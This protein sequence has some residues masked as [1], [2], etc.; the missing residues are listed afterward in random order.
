MLFSPDERI[1]VVVFTNRV[2]NVRPV[3]ELLLT[4]ARLAP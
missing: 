2:A 3:V 4:E 1:G